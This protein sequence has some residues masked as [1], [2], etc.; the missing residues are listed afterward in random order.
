MLQPAM[1][2]GWR[3]VLI[4]E[5]V[6]DFWIH[7]GFLESSSEVV[8]SAVMYGANIDLKLSIHEPESV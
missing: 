8:I 1:F 5:E 2:Y 6:L 4:S 7:R 3:P